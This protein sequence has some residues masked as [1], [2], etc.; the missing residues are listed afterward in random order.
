MEWI[1]IPT[2][3]I[4]L[5]EFTDTQLMILIKY[6]ALYCQLEREPNDRQL[7]RYFT[8]KQMK[9]IASNKLVIVEQASNDIENLNK[10]RGRDKLR[11]SENKESHVNSADGKLSV[12][13]LSAP[14]EKRREEKS[15]KKDTNV[16][17]KK[18]KKPLIEELNYYCQ[19]RNNSVNAE[20]FFDYYEANGWKVGKNSMKNWQAA[21]RTWEKNTNQENKPKETFEERLNRA[22]KEQEDETRNN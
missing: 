10:K 6:Q 11:Y 7:S 2:D 12:S 19:E 13:Q 1:K 15:I 5:P 20:K 9:F 22:K 8:K 16:S 3:S 18:F 4:L 17:T 21:I 14:T